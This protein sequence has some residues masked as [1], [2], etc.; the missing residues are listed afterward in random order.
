MPVVLVETMNGRP[1]RNNSNGY[2][3]M[4]HCISAALGQP[5]RLVAYN[6]Y[7]VRDYGRYE[8]ASFSEEAKR[9]WRDEHWEADLQRAFETGARIAGQL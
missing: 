6:T 2:G 4:E 7:Q 9:Q 1:E 3:S 8:L 5:D